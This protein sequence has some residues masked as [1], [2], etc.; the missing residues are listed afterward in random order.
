[1]SKSPVVSLGGVLQV[2]DVLF[3][4]STS[5]GFEL[6]VT[7][8]KALFVLNPEPLIVI[9]ESPCIKAERVLVSESIDN[10]FDINGQVPIAH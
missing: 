3:A 6:M 8:V 2:S 7:V 4:S 5:H 10:T 9:N 1:M